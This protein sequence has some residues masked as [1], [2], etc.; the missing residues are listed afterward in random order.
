MLTLLLA[1]LAPRR[2]QGRP[3]W[4]VRVESR[5]CLAVGLVLLAVWRVPMRAQSCQAGPLEWL[6]RGALLHSTAHRLVQ[7][8]LAPLLH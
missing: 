8:W 2:R 5:A 6:A 7:A 4:P 1:R 3:V